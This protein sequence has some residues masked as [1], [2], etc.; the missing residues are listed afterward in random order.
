MMQPSMRSFAFSIN[1][2]SIYFPAFLSAGKDN[3]GFIGRILKVISKY[4]K[5]FFLKFNNV[6]T[7][8]SCSMEA[9]IDNVLSNLSSNNA[10]FIGAST[11]LQ[12]N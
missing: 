9:R 4:I 12:N 2:Y 3:K 6:I 10:G 7:L 11:D 1:E 5:K 8:V